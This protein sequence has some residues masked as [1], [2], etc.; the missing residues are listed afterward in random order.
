MNAHRAAL[1]ALLAALV[2]YAV[3][4]VG[5]PASGD[6][7]AAIHAIYSRWP[8][9]PNPAPFPYRVLTVWSRPIFALAYALPGQ[10]GFTA[11]RVFT[12][13]VC[14]V[15]G[16]LVYLLARRLKLP[17]PWLAVPLTLLQPVMLQVGMDVM[18]EPLFAL[19]L[20][21]GMLAL[22][23]GRRLLAACLWSLL[24]LARPEGGPV[25]AVLGLVW[26]LEALRNRR[27]LVPLLGLGLGLVLWEATVLALTGN[28]RYL[29]E[30]F[31]WPVQ[32]DQWQ[33]S[34]FHYLLRWPLILG[35]AG[36]VSWLLGLRPSWR[37]G[38]SLRLCVLFVSAVLAVHAFLFAT[39]GF[40]STG[41]ER[42]FATLAPT[43]GLIALA[44]VAWLVERGARWVRY[45]LPPLLALQ[46]SQ[47]VLWIEGQTLA[48]L[49]KATLQALH[50]ARSRVNLEGRFVIASDLHAFVFL[51]IDPG[52]RDARLRASRDRALKRIEELPV[53]TVVI[54]DSMVGHWW[55]RLDVEDFTARGYQ[56]LWEQ[57]AEL[58]S[59]LLNRPSGQ[60][61]RQA[62]LLRQTGPE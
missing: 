41:F 3:L 42:Y 31:P 33:G 19:L 53:G 55:Y 50:E 32:S 15:T 37:A 48:H 16:W 60:R 18:T 38:G 12:V 29:L 25:L 34:P 61:L 45:A 30:T 59:P 46:A 11:M 35:V 39:G 14:A 24:P 6:Q 47:G 4:L 52:P 20:A 43:N 28:W 44:G 2:P 56:V 9:D 40:A 5:L 17:H 51:D 23:S 27:A 57:E 26:G 13:A 54:W 7:D 21:A 58:R 8:L 49:P 36:L 1:A 62:V 22:E 10:L